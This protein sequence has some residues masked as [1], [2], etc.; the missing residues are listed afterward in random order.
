MK[1]SEINAAL[2]WAKELLARYDI[3]LPDFALLDHGRVAGPQN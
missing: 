1:R 2:T 3:R